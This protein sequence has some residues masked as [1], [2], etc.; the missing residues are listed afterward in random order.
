MRNAAL[1]RAKAALGRAETRRARTDSL[2]ILSL[3]HS[4]RNYEG[5]YADW[6]AKNKK[7][8]DD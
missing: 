3:S 2:I 7:E 6:E 8:H 5:S 1:R 4:L